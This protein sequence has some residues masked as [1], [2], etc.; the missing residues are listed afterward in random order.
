MASSITST[1]FTMP[2]PSKKMV[3]RFLENPLTNATP[4]WLARTGVGLESQRFLAHFC[5]PSP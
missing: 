3:S 4:L 2:P 5:S 1:G